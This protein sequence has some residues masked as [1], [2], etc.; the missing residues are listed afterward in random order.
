MKSEDKK[1]EEMIEFGETPSDRH[2]F[3]SVIE[4]I[5]NHNKEHSIGKMI[6]RAF[7]GAIE[8]EDIPDK[9]KSKKKVMLSDEQ[10]MYRGLL[11]VTNEQTLTAVGLSLTPVREKAIMLVSNGTLDSVG[12][13]RVQVADGRKLI[14]FLSRLKP[15]MIGEDLNDAIGKVAEDLLKEAF[16]TV[17]SSDKDDS[18]EL[19]AYMNGIVLAMEKAGIQSESI[20]KLKELA[21]H[22]TAGDVRE[23]ILA[24]QIGLY[25]E[26]GGENYGPSKWQSDARK[27]T[28][29]KKWTKVI[30][31][32]E[33]AKKN[34]NAINL[35]N[36]LLKLAQ[37]NLDYAMK[38][39]SSEKNELGDSEKEYGEGFDE[40]FERISLEISLLH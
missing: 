3:V 9:K 20:V 40:V 21:Q 22:I 11:G 28:L 39:W 38:D 31:V 2:A 23:F 4:G 13:L 35:F 32:L 8:S 5:T 29:E 15:G 26:I 19:L 7:A 36:D 25:E 33:M 6:G 17:P 14:G 34:P 18:L 24:K 27:E 1:P 12:E 10:E 37:E 30:Q 16:E